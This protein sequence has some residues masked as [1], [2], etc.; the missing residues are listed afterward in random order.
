MRNYKELL[1]IVNQHIDNI[2]LEMQPQK[3]Y[4]PISYLINLGGKRLRPT[5]CLMA[6]ELHGANI[7]EAID[8]AIGIEL[9]HNFTLAHDDILDKSETRRGNPTIH[10]KWNENVAIL[11]GDAM[12]I[13]AYQYICKSKSSR[14]CLQVFNKTAMQVCE[15]QQYDMDYENEIIITVPEY[16]NMIRLKTAVLIATS[17][18]I[19]ALAANATKK[20]QDLIYNFGENLGIAFQLQDDLLDTYGDAEKLG[21]TIGDDIVTNKKTFLLI[22]TLE[23]L[24]DEKKN[25]LISILKNEITFSSKEKKINAVKTIYDSVG[26]KDITQDI[27]DKYFNE[28][29]CNLSK[30]KTVEENKQAI[31]DY[32]N[33][34]R[35]RLA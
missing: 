5:L 29:F 6:A 25:K 18:K 23:M 20:E 22:K 12:L 27:I 34:L 24:K 28:A 31:I 35:N 10:T 4:E 11:S 19:G 16:I 2:H 14:A 7:E 32:T 30:I 1:R 33:L 3:L 17:L 9:F 8:L 13:M 21:K 26:I 15:G